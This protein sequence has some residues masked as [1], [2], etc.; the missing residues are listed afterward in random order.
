MSKNRIYLKG[1]EE[2]E[3]IP[4][5][6]NFF[7]KMDQ[8]MEKSLKKKNSNPN[9]PE[10]RGKYNRF[11]D[12]DEDNPILERMRHILKVKD[13]PLSNQVSR[14]EKSAQQ[15]DLEEDKRARLSFAKEAEKI[16]AEN[17]ARL[18]RENE[19]KKQ[20]LQDEIER[21]RAKQKESER[22]KLTERII[23]NREGSGYNPLAARG[24]E[25]GGSK[26]RNAR[27]ALTPD[28][29]PRFVFNLSVSQPVEGQKQNTARQYPQKQAPLHAQ[30]ERKQPLQRP[31]QAT[32]LA[33]PGLAI[34]ERKYQQTAVPQV[35]QYK[36]AYNPLS[37]QAAFSRP[38]NIQNAKQVSGHTAAKESNYNPL[39][40]NRSDI[41]QSNPTKAP[42]LP[43]PKQLQTYPDNQARNP[44]DSGSL[45]LRKFRNMRNISSENEGSGGKS[46]EKLRGSDEYTA[47]SKQKKVSKKDDPNYEFCFKCQILHEKNLHNKGY[48]P[49][50][51]Q[52][53]SSGEDERPRRELE[54][55]KKILNNALG[56][57]V[58][59]QEY[60]E[61]EEE[62][63]DFEDDF[64]YDDDFIDR[65]DAAMDYKAQLR[66]ITGYN[67]EEYDDADFDDR[68]MEVRNHE[69]LE[70]EEARSRYYGALE[71][72]MEAEKSRK[73]AKRL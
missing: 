51:P 39:K 33:K 60:S 49:Q 66:R 70:R 32:Q 19:L 38:S 59:E 2:V 28:V 57:R 63:D 54:E 37:N 62:E 71:D 23:E 15:P 7:D 41:P 22:A 64:D 27:E 65:G 8:R 29:D 9:N 20:R 47:V 21:D 4:F 56:K 31:M 30:S 72:Q 73:P 26:A 25:G 11:E 53:V 1:E 18:Q 46:G 55:R 61:G 5:A 58:V 44:K 6:S 3:D 24:K 36:A 12:N 43:R 50:L 48:I 40:Q 45:D 34:P 13:G 67:P 68:E 16:R 69:V 14:E 52:R 10:N 17:L 35:E 42:P